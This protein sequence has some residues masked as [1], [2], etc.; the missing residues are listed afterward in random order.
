MQAFHHFLRI[1]SWQTV[2]VILLALIATYFCYK[3]EV[4]IDLPTAIIGIAIVFPIVF[5]IN[6]AYRRREE[7]LGYYSSVKAHGVALVLN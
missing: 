2:I 7:A 1:I 3:C 4:F 5:S 6:A